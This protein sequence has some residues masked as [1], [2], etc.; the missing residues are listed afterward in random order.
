MYPSFELFSFNY[1]DTYTRHVNKIA[2]EQGEG[3]ESNVF[4]VCVNFLK[5]QHVRIKGSV[6]VRYIFVYCRLLSL[7]AKKSISLRYIKLHIDTFVMIIRTLTQE[8]NILYELGK[9]NLGKI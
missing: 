8:A 6:T 3:H 2:V 9:E 5:Q 4:T 1:I 7:F